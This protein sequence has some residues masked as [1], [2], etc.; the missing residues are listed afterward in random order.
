MENHNNKG[1]KNIC[2]ENIN[3]R[4]GMTMSMAHTKKDSKKENVTIE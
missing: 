3:W 1:W 4:T 2:Q